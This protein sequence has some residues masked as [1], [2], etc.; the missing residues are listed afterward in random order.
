MARTDDIEPL[1]PSDEGALLKRGTELVSLEIKSLFGV[2]DHRVE[3]PRTIEPSDD[4]SLV[5][6][7]GRNG[8]GK[9]TTLL[10]LDGLLRLDFDVFRVRPFASA[11]LTLSSRR[12][13]RVRSE[14][15]GAPLHI[16]F[17]SEKVALHPTR[18]GPNLASDQ[19]KVDSL[20]KAFNEA[21]RDIAFQLI[22]TERAHTDV[23]RDIAQSDAYMNYARASSNLSDLPEARLA[24]RLRYGPPEERTLSMHQRV[25]RI[26]DGR[27]GQLSKLLSNRV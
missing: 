15:V 16:S 26:R 1:A 19:S 24:S 6:L 17:G 11:A 3:F 18:K 21:S 27:P 22:T 12:V 10:M 20:K 25:R 5:V 23:E 4:P 7:H 8:S 2:S 9:T 13:L 14:G